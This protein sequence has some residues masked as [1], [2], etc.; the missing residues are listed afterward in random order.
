MG[1]MSKFETFAAKNPSLN[2]SN[3]E[4]DSA[5]YESAENLYTKGDCEGSRKQFSA[6]LNKFENA[7]FI[8]NANYYKADCDLKA[9][10]SLNALSSFNAII[11]SYPGS[12][13]FGSKWSPNIDVI[14]EAIIGNHFGGFASAII[15]MT[16]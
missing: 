4:L 5:T 16:R 7:I 2:I 13:V 9:K 10:D 12:E 1:E 3:A 8:L 14:P 6:Y 15:L 11:N